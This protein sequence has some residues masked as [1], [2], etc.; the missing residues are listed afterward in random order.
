VAFELG[1]KSGLTCVDALGRDSSWELD[2]ERRRRA[3]LVSGDVG[4]GTLAG[5]VD[6]RRLPLGPGVQAAAEVAVWALAS[7][8]PGHRWAV[9]DRG[10]H[11]VACS[12]G[13]PEAWRFATEPVADLQLE[14]DGGWLSIVA[15]AGP[16]AVDESDRLVARSVARL[17]HSVI[18]TDEQRRRAEADAEEAWAVANLDPVTNV[19]NARGLWEEVAQIP[20]SKPASVDVTVARVSIDDLK[21]LN[22]RH[23][24]LLGD[25]V[26]RSLAERLEASLRAGDVVARLGGAEFVVL[27]HHF[28]AEGLRRRI[29]AEVGEVGVAVHI[30]VAH[31]ELGEPI[32]TTVA[33]ADLDLRSRRAAD[34]TQT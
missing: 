20:W 6:L 10:G 19:L 8:R 12:T 16:A 11:V 33:R 4:S 1:L 13:E 27:A 9:L 14:D 17:L 34:P 26:L 3:D 18:V 5:D 28:E 31:H 24:H 23:G 25:Q 7:E 30:G 29:A 21:D 32:R 2:V 22:Q 15:A